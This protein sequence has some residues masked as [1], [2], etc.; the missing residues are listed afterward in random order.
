MNEIEEREAIEICAH[1][2]PKLYNFKFREMAYVP[3]YR[4]DEFY[5]RIPEINPIYLD[6]I[7]H[8]FEV[9]VHAKKG[10]FPYE[11]LRTKAP[12]QSLEEWEYQCGLY[13]SYTRSIWGRALNK[14]KI[15]ANKQNYSITGWDEEQRKYFYEDYPF[16]HSVE[17]YF[18][19]IVRESKIN[20]PNQLL[21]I[22]PAYIPTYVDGE[23][24]VKVVQSVFI[25]PVVRIVEE[26][27]II[28]YHENHLTIIEN[29]KRRF[30]DTDDIAFKEFYKN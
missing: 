24:E 29:G 3:K 15:I 28:H 1:A 18:F 10:V 13:E 9:S 14:T 11:L 21:I 30:N 26:Q 2:A 7:R 17:S 4:I 27:K 5:N 23:G 6:T 25:D 12:N 22:E 8:H 19:D 20:F 16:Y